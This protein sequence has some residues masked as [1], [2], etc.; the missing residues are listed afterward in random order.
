MQSVTFKLKGA[1]I[2]QAITVDETTVGD[3]LIL[4]QRGG[5]RVG[6]LK[7]KALDYW[8]VHDVPAEGK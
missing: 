8:Y 1:E 6:E 5:V 4:L 2:V 3:D 7:R